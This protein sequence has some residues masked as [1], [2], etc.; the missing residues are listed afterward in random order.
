MNLTR[1]Y[2]DDDDRVRQVLNYGN[3]HSGAAQNT[4][5]SYSSG[6]GDARSMAHTP[7]HHGYANPIMIPQ[8]G[9]TTSMLSSSVPLAYSQDPQVARWI[10]T[11]AFRRIETDPAGMYAELPYLLNNPS[12]GYSYS[13]NANYPQQMSDRYHMPMEPNPGPGTFA[14]P[15]CYSNTAGLDYGQSLT[16]SYTNHN[17]PD[18]MSGWN[19]VGALSC[20]NILANN[21]MS[22]VNLTSTA[23]DFAFVHVK[24][25]LVVAGSKPTGRAS[26]GPNVRRDE[27]QYPGRRSDGR[28][29]C[30]KCLTTSTGSWRRHPPNSGRT[31]LLLCN[32]CGLALKRNPTLDGGIWGTL[33]E[34]WVGTRTA[35][36][37]II[38]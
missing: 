24:V 5:H 36:A 9:D 19:P 17:Q 30:A 29:Q 23:Y 26:A 31:G 22:G 37:R 14:G 15:Q 12:L 28:K 10:L 6:Y 21:L 18:P 7:Y 35:L 34:A 27:S 16:E 20:Q 13:T 38:V 3:Y 4:Q 11:L 32:R 33:L 25:D 1:L 8:G 2:A